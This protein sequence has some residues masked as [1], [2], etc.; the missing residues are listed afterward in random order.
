[1]S[2]IF[3][4]RCDRCRDELTA[5]SAPKLAEAIEDHGWHSGKFGRTFLHYCEPCQ[6]DNE[7]LRREILRKLTWGDRP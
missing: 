4:V 5:S 6:D 7:D 3:G 1:M 2:R